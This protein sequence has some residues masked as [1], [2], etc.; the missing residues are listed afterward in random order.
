MVRYNLSVN[1]TEL[2]TVHIKALSRARIDDY[3]DRKSNNAV[4]RE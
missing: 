1:K 2:F 4:D 3:L